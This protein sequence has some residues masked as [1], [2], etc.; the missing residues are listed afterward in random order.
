MDPSIGGVVNH[1]T[2]EWRAFFDAPVIFITGGAA[3]AG[4]MWALMKWAFGARLTSKDERITARDERIK[5]LEL[6][7]DRFERKADWLGSEV[8][9]LTLTPL[10]LR[11]VLED[12]TR[13]KGLDDFVK[14]VRNRTEDIAT[15]AATFGGGFP[16]LRETLR[17]SEAFAQARTFE[18]PN[19][20]A[21]PFSP[22]MDKVARQF[23]LDA[24]R[25]LHR[26][27]SELIRYLVGGKGG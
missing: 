8:A 11:F 9:R 4:A 14:G 15:R 18:Q 19:G 13:M 27:A 23:A 7:V 3:I 22:E 5:S 25:D 26:T 16:G 2:L 17:A 24:C 20:M 6:E 10:P 21:E 1:L 12:I